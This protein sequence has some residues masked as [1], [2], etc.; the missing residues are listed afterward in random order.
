MKLA[1]NLGDAHF[2]QEMTVFRCF[3]IYGK[4]NNSL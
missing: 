3:S 4:D 1:V 2:S